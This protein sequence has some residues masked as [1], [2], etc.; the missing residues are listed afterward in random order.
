MA[1]RA[2]IFIRDIETDEIVRTIETSYEPDSA[3]YDRMM[4]G[5]YMRVDLERFYIEE[6]SP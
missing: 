3:Q 4:D 1:T 6:Q 5:M 2:H